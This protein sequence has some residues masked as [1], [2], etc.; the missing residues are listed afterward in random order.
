[1]RVKLVDLAH[2]QDIMAIGLQQWLI[3]HFLNKTNRMI[4]DIIRPNII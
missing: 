2:D 1:M 4:D 3:K